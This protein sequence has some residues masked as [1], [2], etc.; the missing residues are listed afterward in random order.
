MQDLKCLSPPPPPPPPPPNT[1]THKQELE[2]R[3][4]IL[5]A[6]SLEAL[7][8]LLIPTETHDPEVSSVVH[9]MLHLNCGRG[10]TRCLDPP[11]FLTHRL[12]NPP[13]PIHCKI[14]CL[15]VPELVTVSII[16]VVN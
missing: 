4:G 12:L 2:Y 10:W 7:I 3:D 1:H 5:V 11:T 14:S 15:H 9:I 16:T 6:G 13:A 8:D